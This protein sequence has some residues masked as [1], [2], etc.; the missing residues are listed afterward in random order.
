MKNLKVGEVVLLYIEGRWYCRTII[1]VGEW[2]YICRCHEDGRRIPVFKSFANKIYR[3]FNN[4]IDETTKI[5]NTKA[6]G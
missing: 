2:V 3:S 5:K 1:G 4:Y 6:T